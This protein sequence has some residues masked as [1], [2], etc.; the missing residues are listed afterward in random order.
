ML[1]QTTLL[2]LR[3]KT[4]LSRKIKADRIDKAFK[5]YVE[6]RCNQIKYELLPFAF[7]HHAVF[8]GSRV[9]SCEWGI[10]G[11]DGAAQGLGDWDN[12]GRS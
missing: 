6:E 7:L 2:L 11:R 5:M 1:A 12:S 4:H 8:F 10:D 3:V 9:S